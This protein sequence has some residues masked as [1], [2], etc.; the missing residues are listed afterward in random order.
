VP[1]PAPADRPGPG[2]L[3]ILRGETR[4]GIAEVGAAQVGVLVDLARKK[5]PTQRAVRDKAGAEFFQ[6]PVFAGLSADALTKL[7]EKMGRE[8]FPLAS[9]S[10]RGTR[11]TI[12]I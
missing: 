5:A 10:V 11:E 8:R 1:R 7:A 6:R 9:S 4:E 12:S 3:W 2:S